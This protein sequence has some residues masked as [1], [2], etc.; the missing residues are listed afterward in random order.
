[1]RSAV[2]A[3]GAEHPS[4]VTALAKDPR[5]GVSRPS[6]TPSRQEWPVD[7]RRDPL[8]GLVVALALVPEA[9]AFSIIGGVDP[10]VAAHGTVNDR[11]AMSSPTTGMSTRRRT[12]MTAAQMVTAIIRGRSR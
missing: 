12:V 11:G 2:G 4:D 5:F 10:R 9:I 7:V 8:A 3:H 1:M 6:R